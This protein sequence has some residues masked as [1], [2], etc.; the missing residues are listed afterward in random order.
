M[1]VYGSGASELPP[2]TA[3]QVLG[4]E[5]G[6]LSSLS[7]PRDSMVLSILMLWIRQTPRNLSVSILI[8]LPGSHFSSHPLWGHHS[9]VM[10]TQRYS[11]FSH[12]P[13][14]CVAKLLRPIYAT[15][16]WQWLGR[17]K[18]T[19][20]ICSHFVHVLL[21][22]LSLWGVC[23]ARGKFSGNLLPKYLIGSEAESTLSLVFP[24]PMNTPTSPFWDIGMMKAYIF[25]VCL[26]YFCLLCSSNL[27]FCNE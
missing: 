18:L 1:V 12:S 10:G 6:T 16:F 9:T 22:P 19:F 7:G 27:D 24:L 25:L 11:E 15:E 20:S 26:S 5:V 3:L 13:L 14:G 23:E 21:S 8:S 2:Q 17:A 4:D